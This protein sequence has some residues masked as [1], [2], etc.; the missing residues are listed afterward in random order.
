MKRR[1][2]VQS[3]LA[4]EPQPPEALPIAGRARVASGAV[5]AMGLE[6]AR[7]TDEAKEATSLREQIA[8]GVSVVDLDPALVEPSFMADR[9]ARNSDADYRKLVDSIRTAGQQVP[10]LVRPHP[11]KP[12][13]YQVA[14]GHRR[15]DA[16]LELGLPVKAIIRP[17]TDQ[18]LVVAQGKENAER[19]NLSF[20]ERALFAAA[21][22]QKGF[23]RATVNAAL[24][25][26]TSEMTRLL[27]V[28]R[29]VPADI[30][31]A[32]GPAPK[33]GRPRWIELAKLLERDA[34]LSVARQ[35]LRQGP[36]QSLTSDRRFDAL[37]QELRAD[38]DG[39]E[40]IV[41]RST[42]GVVVV[43]ADRFSRVLRLSV[44]ERAAPE[45]GGRLL[46]LLPELV[47]QTET[48]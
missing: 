33:A 7:L 46:A 32:I 15:R 17:L 25:V 30:I 38:A 43:R 45:L 41:F 14:F 40:P 31:Q 20:I 29:S 47:R 9:L 22:D 48:D 34:G 44:D 6:L 11:D 8:S 2:L 37:I 3:L 36:F 18:E 1:D 5:R 4:A 13:G 28:A 21:L 42:K 24:S 35:A 23:S 39:S 12:V 19:R 10:I 26:Q 27:S 16:A